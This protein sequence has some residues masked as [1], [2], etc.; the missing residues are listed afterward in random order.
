MVKNMVHILNVNV[1]S[2]WMCILLLK[3][4]YRCQLYLVDVAVELN[5]VL[6]DFLPVE[7]AHL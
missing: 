4:I 5:Y 3:L 2:K 1:N 7:S 6:T